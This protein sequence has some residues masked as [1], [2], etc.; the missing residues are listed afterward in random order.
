M[1]SAMATGVSNRLE[2]LFTR[3]TN[4]RLKR[5]VFRSVV[6]LQ[7]AINHFIAETNENPK[8]AN[9]TKSSSPSN[10]GTSVGSGG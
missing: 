6:E 5:G 4:R 7:A 1:T 9:P 8:P 10:A 3:V 2:G